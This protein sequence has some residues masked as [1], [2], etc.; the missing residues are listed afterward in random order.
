MPNLSGRRAP[1]ARERIEILLPSERS[2]FHARHGASQGRMVRTFVRGPLVCLVPP[3]T[4]HALECQRA[5]DVVILALDRRF[6]EERAREVLATQPRDLPAR[7][8]AHDPFMRALGETLREQFARNTIQDEG[9]LR[10]LAGTVAT[11][12]AFNYA[13]PAGEQPSCTG[14]AQDKVQR[15]YQHVDAHLG[16]ALAVRSLAALVHMSPYH[17]AR[18]FKKATGQAPHGYITARR[19]ARARTLLRES[20]L[21]L[22][23]VAAEVGFQTQGHFT[24]VFHRHTGATPRAYRLASRAELDAMHAAS[25]VDVPDGAADLALP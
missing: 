22:V 10:A 14:L 15:I 9:Y 5:A 25:A 19:V 21:P 24:V 8:C 18:M 7:Y 17:F 11:Y 12:L 3:R 23:D 20:S 13:G 6:F 16:E 1:R 2:A 4:P